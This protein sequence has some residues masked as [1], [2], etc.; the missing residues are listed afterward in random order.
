LRLAR[1]RV[2]VSVFVSVS[3]EIL[4]WIFFSIIL[5]PPLFVVVF[6]PRPVYLLFA[7]LAAIAIQLAASMATKG[8]PLFDF[9]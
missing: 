2:Y 9:Y 5:W 3:V 8:L 7:L 1:H 6:P 4:I